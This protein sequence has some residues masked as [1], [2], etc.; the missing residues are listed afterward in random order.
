MTLKTNSESIEQWGIFEISLD[1]PSDGNPF[2]DVQL[3]AQFS[4]QNRVIE[5]DGFYDGAGVYRIRFMPDTPGDWRFVTKSNV[6]ALDGQTGEFNCTPATEG[7]HGP[8]KVSNVFHFAYADDTPY[9]SFGTTCY[10]WTHQGKE[11][12]EQTLATLKEAP[13]NKM[14]MCVFPKDYIYNENEPVYY[15]FARD[16]AGNHNYDRFDPECFRH[17]EQSVGDLLALGIEADIIIWHP[18]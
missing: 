16:D 18:L 2:Q 12:E 4:L 14:R 13:F 11:L 3:S 15:P 8:V 5:P 17:F 1:G 6:A 9:Y 10:A 7:N